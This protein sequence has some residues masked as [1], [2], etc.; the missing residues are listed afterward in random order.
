MA[1]YD[2]NDPF[3]I[4][5]M[6]A[7]F[8]DY[9]SDDW[10]H[11]IEIAKEKKLGFDKV[12]TLINAKKNTRYSKRLSPKQLVVILSLVDKIDE[13]VADDDKNDK[14]T[15]L[16]E[17]DKFNMPI[18][19]ATFR[20]AWHDNKWN[21]TICNNPENNTYCNGFHSLLSERIRKRKEDNMA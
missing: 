9:S 13:M 2:I 18:S 3:D 17:N 4:D 6:N 19:H 12:S 8:D 5:I 1:K 21:G 14:A 15:E 10:E 11:Y 7:I 16:F 20:V